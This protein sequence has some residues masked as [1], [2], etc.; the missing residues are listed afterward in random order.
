LL[1]YIENFP[2]IIADKMSSGNQT[3]LSER[4]IAQVLVEH[5]HQLGYVVVTELVLDNTLFDIKFISGKEITKLRIDV[6][7]FKDDKITFIEVE[8]GLWITHPLLYREFAHR[9]ILAYPEEYQ[10]PT[11]QEQIQMAKINGIGIVSIS[12]DRT[13]KSILRPSELNIPKARTNAIISLIK[14]R[15]KKNSLE[16]NL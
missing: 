6:A 7:A 2:L 15:L 9:V 5:L 10:A 1:I 4:K 8:N 11:D 3:Q 14:K 13:I 16:N 12:F